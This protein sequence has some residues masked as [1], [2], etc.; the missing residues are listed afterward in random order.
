MFSV[1]SLS[2]IL[3]SISSSSIIFEYSS[4]VLLASSTFESSSKLLYSSI[5]TSNSAFSSSVKL[6]YSSLISCFSWICN[7]SWV[8]STGVSISSSVVS[9]KLY[10]TLVI[11]N[12]VNLSFDKKCFIEIILL[13]FALIKS[14]S[15]CEFG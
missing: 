4:I 9:S 13:S 11:L 1:T 3:L 15:L 5:F 10:S 6:L 14:Y 7:S 8:S 2:S 12:G